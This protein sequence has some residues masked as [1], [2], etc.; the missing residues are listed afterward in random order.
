MGSC[1]LPTGGTVPIQGE[2]R[3]HDVTPRASTGAAPAPKSLCLKMWVSELCEGPGPFPAAPAA[4]LVMF[5]AF[6]RRPL[7][8]LC[9]RGSVLGP[10]LVQLRAPPRA[11]A[12]TRV[13][14]PSPWALVS[15]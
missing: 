7:A 15:L 14:G 13:K 9:C 11:L 12:H 5:P 1:P 4:S 6:S 8:A 2:A 3:V 10:F